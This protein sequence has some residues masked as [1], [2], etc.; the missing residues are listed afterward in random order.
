VPGL[1]HD[2][3]LI[4]QLQG[5]L[6]GKSIRAGVADVSTSAAVSGATTV[7]H[8][9]G[10]TPMAVMLTALSSGV[11]SENA[12]SVGSTTFDINITYVDGTARTATVPVYWLVIG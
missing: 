3:V 2:A 9:L 6:G 11:T 1:S 4:R 12:A 5:M 8:G 7:T 10:R